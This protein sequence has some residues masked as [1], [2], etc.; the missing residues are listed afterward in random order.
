LAAVFFA[1]ALRAAVAG[2]FGAALRTGFLAVLFL[3]GAAF[4]A[5]DFLA[6][7]A[8]FLAAVGRAG[9]FA[10]TRFAGAAVFLA[11]VFRATF[12]TTLFA[13]VLRT[14]LALFVTGFRAVALLIAGLRAAAFFVAGLRAA[15]F[16]APGSAI[17][18]SIWSRPP[19]EHN[20]F[21]TH[22][23]SQAARSAHAPI[24]ENAPTYR[25]RRIVGT[26][27]MRAQQF[28]HDF[29]TIVAKKLR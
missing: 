13:A 10:A 18:V 8:A 27:A 16:F 26:Y 14:A 19:R 29:G 7:P 1:T 6:V 3:A 25:A 11:A 28:M 23:S 15:V 4:F 12:F 2:F 5:V 24:I 17:N 9:F 20:F 22:A 21:A